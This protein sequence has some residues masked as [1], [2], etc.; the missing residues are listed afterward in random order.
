MANR[1]RLH[2][3]HARHSKNFDRLIYRSQK[4]GREDAISYEKRDENKA[5]INQTE[6]FLQCKARNNLVKSGIAHSR[7][8]LIT[9]FGN[10]TPDLF[11]YLQHVH[12][13][14]CVSVL[15]QTMNVDI[16]D[17]RQPSSRVRRVSLLALHTTPADSM[18]GSAKCSL[19]V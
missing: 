4:S 16:S 14:I 15:L 8:R 9:S 17:A 18:G 12:S 19:S 7:S 11:S 6:S 2:A 5:R 10:W 13:E 1:N 3:A